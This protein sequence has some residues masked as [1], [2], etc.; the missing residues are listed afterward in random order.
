MNC[1]ISGEVPEEPV[2]S[3]KSG[4]LFE[5]RLIE[6]HISVSS[7]LVAVRALRFCCISILLDACLYTS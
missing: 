4:L 7:W 5:K 1:S 6:R 2:I 3:K